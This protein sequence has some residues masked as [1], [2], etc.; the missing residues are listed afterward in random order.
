MP[1]ERN[2]YNLP[3]EYDNYDQIQRFKRAQDRIAVT[4]DDE[5]IHRL[6][7]DRRQ[8]SPFLRQVSQAT[9]IG[10]L[11]ALAARKYIG[12][13]NLR[14]IAGRL[15]SMADRVRNAS[16][17]ASNMTAAEYLRAT[18]YKSNIDEIIRASRED[19]PQVRHL[20]IAQAV[21]DISKVYQTMHDPH[22]VPDS[23][24]LLNQIVAA[25]KKRIA[26]RFSA[27]STSVNEIQDLTV[28]KIMDMST[29]LRKEL[30]A[31]SDITAIKEGL[32]SGFITKD[33]LAG[34]GLFWDK[35]KDKFIHN[36]TM[37][38]LGEAVRTISN[39]FNIPFTGIKFG[40]LLS[41]PVRH[42]L[43]KG[44]YA[45]V[46]RM[47]G[48]QS[49]AA[50][51][52]G[53]LFEEVG[54]QAGTRLVPRGTGYK[55]GPS[56][57]MAQAHAA[58][59]GE[60]GSQVR[61]QYTDKLSD[62]VFTHSKP[63]RSFFMSL[64]E[65]AGIGPQYRTQNSLIK[66]A[67]WDM[68]KRRLRGEAILKESVPLHRDAGFSDRLAHQLSENLGIDPATGKKLSTMTLGE[69]ARMVPPRIKLP[70]SY[71][72]LGPVDKLKSLFGSEEKAIHVDPN[73]VRTPSSSVDP[74]LI[75]LPPARG[76]VNYGSRRLFPGDPVV[77]SLGNPQEVCSTTAVLL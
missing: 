21:Q 53:E 41:A 24:G 11:A 49:R 29:G 62:P 33:T 16:I 67:V 57:V 22:N 59:I 20:E 72:D 75:P 31:G 8:Q 46:G 38:Q 64:S 40:D 28:G 17:K 73:I 37:G 15:T 61:S 63:I 44:A 76:S 36:P 74:R 50:V 19:L 2:R 3:R 18:G 39:Q 52:G 56:G 25:N 13:D 30:F 14:R 9:L 51:I 47:P 35:A 10:S 70:S 1:T 65:L 5:E 42:V 45:G 4:R 32:S 55:V 71:D 26:E 66:G 48:S 12:A 68:P 34:G 60:L 7:E 54:T 58:R 69:R 77:G 43:G 6:V 23:R 27:G